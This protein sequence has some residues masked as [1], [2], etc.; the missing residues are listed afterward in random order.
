MIKN[1]VKDYNIKK[2]KL[3]NSIKTNSAK[4]K[5]ILVKQ[6]IKSKKTFS[7]VYLFKKCKKTR[8]LNWWIFELA[9]Y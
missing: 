9:F 1:F 2:F 8:K 3:Y 6:M 5:K 4:A 7:P